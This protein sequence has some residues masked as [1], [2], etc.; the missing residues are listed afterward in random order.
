MQYAT[1]ISP[2]VVVKA[3]VEEGC[4]WSLFGK[5]NG[6]ALDRPSLFFSRF[7][8]TITYGLE[9]ISKAITHLTVM[10]HCCSAERRR[11]G[12]GPDVTGLFVS[13]YNFSDI[14]LQLLRKL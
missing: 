9:P 7:E 3:L 13:I 12:L 1:M 11:A 4:H 8:C 14:L 6:S 10:N 2:T 5:Q